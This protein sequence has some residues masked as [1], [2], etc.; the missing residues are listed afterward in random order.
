MRQSLLDEPGVP[1]SELLHSQLSTLRKSCLAL[2]YLK[3]PIEVTP[4]K[5]PAIARLNLWITS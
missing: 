3:V 2:L 4:P 5:M 1:G